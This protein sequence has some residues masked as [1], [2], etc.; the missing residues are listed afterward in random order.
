M[1][2]LD[3]EE[4][5][6]IQYKPEE[7]TWPKPS[8]FVVTNV[9]RDREWFAKYMPV[10]RDFWDKVVYHREHGIE[11]PPPKK[12]RKKKEIIRPECTIVTDSDEDYYDEY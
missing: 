7:L 12:P 10:M 3:L 8:E 1:D 4:A 5:D 9:K 6:F 11:D 2:I